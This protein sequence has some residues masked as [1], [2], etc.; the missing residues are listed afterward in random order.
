MMEAQ[1]AFGS[2]SAEVDFRDFTV[3]GGFQSISTEFGSGGGFTFASV[4]Y[5]SSY[6]RNLVQADATTQTVRLFGDGFVQ[7]G[8]GNLTAGTVNAVVGSLSEGSATVRQYYF[9]GVAVSAATFHTAMRTASLVDDQA[10][11]HSM[12]GGND[13]ISLSSFNDFA[14]GALGND[15]MSGNNGAD[16]LFGQAGNDVLRGGYGMDT[17]Y[18]N[19]GADQMIGGPGADILLGGVGNDTLTGG[20][21]VDIFEFR[22]GDNNDRVL[23]WTNGVDELRFYGP[24]GSVSVAFQNLAGGD[25]QVKVLG[26]T[27]IVEN[28]QFADFQLTSGSDYVTLT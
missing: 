12:L 18:G 27:I 1:L 13:I 26:M 20:G 5:D 11:L 25:V 6:V 19:A 10:V 14:Y 28:A 9:T 16:K 15:T 4:N 21:G 17:L 7:N 2:F 24:E 23:D 8:A 3:G 22:T